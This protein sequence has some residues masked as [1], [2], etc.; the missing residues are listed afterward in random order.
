MDV[1]IHGQ[2]NVSNVEVTT[3]ATAVNINGKRLGLVIRNNSDETV[4]LGNASDVT[5]DNGFPL[6]ADEI[7]QDMDGYDSRYGDVDDWYAITASGTVDLRVIE[8]LNA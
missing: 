5:S 1:N 3:E 2:K 4:Y 7:I 6:L 8:Y